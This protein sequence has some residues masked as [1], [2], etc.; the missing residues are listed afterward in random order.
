MLADLYCSSGKYDLAQE[1]CKRCLTHNQ[2][3]A[4]AW[5]YLGLVMEKEQSYADAADAYERAWHFESERSAS[6]GFKLGFNYLKAKRLV[7]FSSSLLSSSRVPS[8][9]TVCTGAVDVL[10]PL[11]YSCLYCQ[12]R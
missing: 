9:L 4:K 5:E 11:P 1:L 12:V 6:V 2:S 7:N 10:T 3:C 8:S